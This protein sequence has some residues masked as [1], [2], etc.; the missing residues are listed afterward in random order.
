MS[1]PVS[2]LEAANRLEN[3]GVIMKLKWLS[4]REFKLLNRPCPQMRC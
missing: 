4:Y 1:R 2:P 3:S